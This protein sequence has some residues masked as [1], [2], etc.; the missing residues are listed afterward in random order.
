MSADFVE[1][2]EGLFGA[3]RGRRAFEVKLG[4]RF[5]F[6]DDGALGAAAGGRAFEHSAS[7]GF[8][9]DDDAELG[10][11]TGARDFEAMKTACFVID[12][13]VTLVEVGRCDDECE[14]ETPA[15]S[16]AYVVVC[17]PLVVVQGGDEAEGVVEIFSVA[18]VILGE[19]DA[20]SVEGVTTAGFGADFEHASRL[21]FVVVPFACGGGVETFSSLES[22]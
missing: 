6:V 16:V 11:K 3:E 17:F 19:S 2:L 1:D 14:T 8:F 15:D 10:G 22:L 7:T 9:V 21:R 12:V 4:V 13:S 5:V 18:V 20:H